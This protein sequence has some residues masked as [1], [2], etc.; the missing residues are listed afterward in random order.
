M[1]I[2]LTKNKAKPTRNQ[3]TL[4]PGY[5]ILMHFV[6]LSQLFSITFLVYLIYLKAFS[7]FE[8]LMY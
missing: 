2:C 5:L 8:S 6:H 1:K 3:T 4:K 7:I